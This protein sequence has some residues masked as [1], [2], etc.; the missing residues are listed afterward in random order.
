MGDFL[1][2]IV[3]NVVDSINPIS[4]F[5]EGQARDEERQRIATEQMRQDN[6]VERRVASARKAGVSPL[7][8]MGMN[9][10]GSVNTELSHLNAGGGQNAMSSTDRATAR[11]NQDI[12]RVQKEGLELDNLKKM[13]DLDL[14]QKTGQPSAGRNVLPGGSQSVKNPTTV[15][16]LPHMSP[17]VPSVS[18]LIEEGN[19]RAP[20]PGEDAKELLEDSPYELRHFFKYGL[21]PNFGHRYGALPGEDWS[22]SQQAWVPEQGEKV[23]VDDYSSFLRRLWNASSSGNMANVDIPVGRAVTMRAGINPS[24]STDIY[25]LVK[26]T[27]N[28]WIWQ[29]KERRR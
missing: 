19:S 16:G 14:N 22:F 6:E 4:W 17:G 12:L 1:S 2:G 8:A 5:K 29:L 3:G 18:W 10:Q 28:G 7:A 15:P 23:N 27:P 24:T 20:V 26:K 21:M 25:K 13:Q 9:P 11:L